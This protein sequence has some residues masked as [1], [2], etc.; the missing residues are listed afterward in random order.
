MPGSITIH[1]DTLEQT[2]K[3]GQQLGKQATAGQIITLAGDL[4]TGKTTLTQAIGLG[5]QVPPT[6][7]ITSPTFSI[8]HEY[9]GRIPMYHMDLYR[10]SGA[11]EIEDLGLLEYLYGH[12]VAIVEWP[13]RLGN[14]LPINRLSIELAFTE[15]LGRTSTLQICGAG[16]DGL[17]DFLD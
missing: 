14:L 13:D 17:L 12:G 16:H 5:L 6:C 7:Y 10:L 2:L 9:P 1:L 8:L 11:E 3:L 4:G 15:K